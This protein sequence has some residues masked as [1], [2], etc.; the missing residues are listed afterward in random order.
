MNKYLVYLCIPILF[1][2][3]DCS[4]KSSPPKVKSEPESP[5]VKPSFQKGEIGIAFYNIENLFDTEDDPAIDDSEFLPDSKL[6]WTADKYNIKLGNMAKVIAALNGGKAPE[7]FGLVEIE[8]ARVVTD[9][10]NQEPLRK[11]GYKFAHHNSKD[12]RGID[13]AL[14]YDPAV[15][16]YKSQCAFTPNFADKDKKTR[17]FLVVDGT[18]G[19][20]EVTFIVNHWP[21]RREGKDASEVYRLTVAEQ[22]KKVCDSISA[23]SPKRIICLMGDFNDDPLDKSLFATFNLQE[24]PETLGKNNF[25]DPMLQLQKDKAEG[26]LEYNGSWNY[27]DQF[28]INKPLFSAKS[29]VQ[30]VANSARIFQ[31]DWLRV[32]YGKAKNSPRRSVFAGKFRDDGYSDHFPVEMKWKVGE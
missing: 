15:F 2:F 25:Y 5:K 32:G 26:S 28:L 19:K 27:F 24:K 9:L 4:P 17:D 14:C 8:N 13:V 18:I 22:V 11:R 20:E 21:S 3:S 30:Y 7:V 12:P 16:G 23:R 10:L 6:Q 1:A 29:D 31:P